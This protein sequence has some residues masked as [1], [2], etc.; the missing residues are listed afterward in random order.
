MNFF[1]K[2]FNQKPTKENEKTTKEVS[3]ALDDLFVQRFIEKGGK[4]IYCSTANEVNDNLKKILQE[5]NW[6]QL[7]LLS[8]DLEKFLKES[9]A[10]IVQIYNS[11]IPIFTECEYL[12][13]EE[14]EILFSS[15]QMKST[16]LSSFSDNF[17]VFAKT[18]QLV[19]KR[20]DALTGIQFNYKGNIPSNISSIKNF[21]LN[22][23]DDSF[24]NYGYSNSKNLYLLLFED[25]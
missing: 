14:C 3:L 24:L 23:E 21:T 1:S 10:E 19:G 8:S 22:K 17:I 25:L 2:L 11:S 5:N 16:K 7:S 18:S 12:I 20:N 4:F 13:A 15:N 6:G 9:N